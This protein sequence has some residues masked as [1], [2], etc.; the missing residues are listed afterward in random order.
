MPTE[1]G[2]ITSL[3]TLLSTRQRSAAAVVDRCL[4]EIAQRDATINAFIT[5]MGDEAREAAREADA[6]IAAGR[7]RGPLHGD[8]VGQLKTPQRILAADREVAVRVSA[9]QEVQERTLGDCR[10]QILELP[11]PIDA[12]LTHPLEIRLTHRRGCDQARQQRCAAIGKTG[13]RRQGKRGGVGADVQ[14]V[15]GPDARERVRHFD[16]AQRAGPLVHH[17]GDDGGQSFLTG[18]I[19]S[20][21]TRH[22]QDERDDRNAAVLDGAHAKAIRERVMHDGRKRETRIGTDRRQ[23]GAI[24]RHQD[25]DTASEPAR[26]SIC[27]PRGTMLNTARRSNRRCAAAAARTVSGVADW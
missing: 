8:D 14:I 3:A 23:L 6:E 1:P 19:G 12:Q 18:G 16:R 11:K 7:Y 21:S 15:F 20:G 5:V 10:R 25:T 24:D 4:D 9:V 17:V 27:W 26:A 13:Q 2:T 22:L